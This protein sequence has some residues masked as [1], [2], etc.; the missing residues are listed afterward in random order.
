MRKSGSGQS[1]G[2]WC[3]LRTSGGSTLALA[4]KLHDAG[5]G[6]WAPRKMESRRRPRSTLTID[7][8]VAIAP[9]FVFV[10][11]E[12][13]DDLWR[14]HSLPMS[15]FPQ[16]SIFTLGQRVPLVSEKDIVGL[17][18]EEER[19]AGIW[20][21][22]KQRLEQRQKRSQRYFYPRGSKVTVSGES[23]FTGLIGIVQSGD[24][25]SAVIDFG[26]GR[27]WKID[28]W[29]LAPN[30]IETRSSITDTAARAA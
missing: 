2:K 6:G 11:A 28:T 13:L 19:A 20:E 10:P 3:I 24:N 5:Y 18:N 7:R 26:G 23:N 9:T 12:R 16:F 27:E 1:Q 15:P 8:E 21:A 4:S 30:A 25:R 29:R 22:M 14:A 17:R